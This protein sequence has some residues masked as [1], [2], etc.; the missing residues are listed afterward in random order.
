MFGA[1]VFV[2]GFRSQSGIQGLDLTGV[3]MGK[4]FVISEA[5]YNA[6]TYG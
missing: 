2:V 6:T 3:L 4:S 5:C 1:D